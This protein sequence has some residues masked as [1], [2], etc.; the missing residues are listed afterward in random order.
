MVP[1]PRGG[2]TLTVLP[3]KAFLFGG[4]SDTHCSQARMGPYSFPVLTGQ[5]SS[6]PS[7]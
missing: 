2:H 5:V 6:L 1:R 3:G 4:H 7:Y